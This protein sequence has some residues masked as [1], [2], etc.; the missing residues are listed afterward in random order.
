MAQ[1]EHC[2]SRQ[3][4]DGGTCCSR[5]GCRVLQVRFPWDNLI[6]SNVLEFYWLV[7][8]DTATLGYLERYHLHSLPCS[9]MNVAYIVD[10]GQ[11]G[12]ATLLLIL[13]RSRAQQRQP[14]HKRAPRPCSPKC[15]VFLLACADRA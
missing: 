9:C 7:T 8:L 6:A 4:C 1:L 10:R 13:Q 2:R 12:H 3:Q 5:E 11:H 15:D 14:Q